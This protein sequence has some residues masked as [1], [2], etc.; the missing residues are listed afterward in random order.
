MTGSELVATNTKTAQENDWNR[1]KE[2]SN[3]IPSLSF[4][5]KR[6]INITDDQTINLKLNAIDDGPVTFRIETNTVD[7]HFVYRDDTTAVLNVTLRRRDYQCDLSVT[8][9][10]EQGFYAP[11]VRLDLIICDG[12]SRHGR[13]DFDTIQTDSEQCSFRKVKCI[14]DPYWEGSSCELDFDGCR[15]SPCSLN[16]SCADVNAYV[17]KTTGIAFNCSQCP[18]GYSKDGNKCLDIDECNKTSDGCNQKCVNTIGSFY[19]EC[20]AGYALSTDRRTCE[21]IDECETH[22]DNCEQICTNAVGSFTCGCFSG[23][24]YNVSMK[25]CTRTALLNVCDGRAIDCKQTAGCTSVNGTAICFCQ[26]GFQLSNQGTTCIDSDECVYN[27][28][29]QICHNSIGGFSCHCLQGYELG[30]DNRTCIECK[31]PKYGNYCQGTCS[32]GTHGVQCHHVKGCKCESGWQGNECQQDIDECTQVPNICSDPFSVC[33]NLAGTYTCQC[34]DGFKKNESGRCQDIDECSDPYWNKCSQLCSNTLRGFT[35]GCKQG[36]QLDHQDRYKCIDVDECAKGSSGCE[37]ICVNTPGLYNCY[38]EYGYK[39]RTDRKT[40]EKETNVCA[41][42]GNMNCSQ[43]C[44]VVDRKPVCVCQQG[45]FL[46][47]DG[48]TCKD[49]N[50]C[51]KKT[52]CSQPDNCFNMDGS[53]S[54]Y[55]SDGYRLDNDGVTCRECDEFHYGKNCN[56]TCNCGIGAA[57]CDKLKGCICKP[58]WQGPRCET[59]VNECLLNNSLCLGKHQMCINTAGS[60]VCTCQNG[61]IRESN[62]SVDCKDLNECDDPV[63]NICDQNCTNTNGSYSCTCNE[64][65]IW[66]DNRCVDINECERSNNCQHICDNLQGSYRC[67]C[68]TGFKIDVDNTMECKPIT[69][70]P[71]NETEFCASKRAQCAIRRGNAVCQC[72]KGFEWNSEHGDC[73]DIIDCDANARCNQQCIEEIGGY[74]CACSNGYRLLENN[75]TCVACDNNTYA[76]G[77]SEICKCFHNNAVNE[78]QT[79]DH[80]NGTCI[81]KAGWEGRCDRDIDECTRNPQIC[82]GTLNSGCHNTIGGYECSCLRGYVRQGNQCIP[83]GETVVVMAVKLDVALGD[84]VNLN[85]MATYEYFSNAAKIAVS[86][87]GEFLMKMKVYINRENDERIHTHQQTHI[88]NIYLNLMMEKLKRIEIISLASGSLIIDYNIYIFN[89]QEVVGNLTLTNVE[90][91]SGASVM[92][93]NKSSGI[94]DVKVAGRMVTSHPSDEELCKLYKLT[95]PTCNNGY[96]C[97]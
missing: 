80:V 7:A 78:T 55:C 85:V 28:C 86:N 6:T 1:T 2:V 22:L 52:S 31:Y 24:T 65:F 40:C 96:M 37:Q 33:T 23:F 62:S 67:L 82:R 59:D 16:R 32:C 36:Y 42:L 95:F 15:G 43:I 53:F 49:I 38:C 26:K 9:M 13:C 74:A 10:D 84:G 61:Y 97:T 88:V 12:C 71:R 58:G 68:Y 54:C 14:C 34:V 51:E 73:I 39:L 11:P 8:A 70:C 17:H 21:D 5:G 76:A 57:G 41:K 35:C 89:T 79:C 92:F 87:R 60:Y 69:E 18:Q 45:Y 48:N 81:C 77:C 91:A 75:V 44:L 72:S 83:D 19:C 90:L 93:E 20:D 64:G 63:L 94:L 30:K 25:V 27:P 29:S 66:Q 4:V 46:D 50:E 56:N 47:T 3:Q